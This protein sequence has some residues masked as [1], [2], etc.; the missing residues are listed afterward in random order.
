M[1]VGWRLLPFNAVVLP[2]WFSK[3]LLVRT[4]DVETYLG[5]GVGDVGTVA[6]G[7]QCRNQG[8]G[9]VPHSI[10]LPFLASYLYFLAPS[11]LRYIAI[12]L[13]SAYEKI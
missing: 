7:R 5:G 6:C 2:D 4:V 12:T 9:S 1:P 8:H 13:P 11:V 3:D 10:S